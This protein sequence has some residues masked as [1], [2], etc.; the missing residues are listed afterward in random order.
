MWFQS[1]QTAPR[2]SLVKKPRPVVFKQCTEVKNIHNGIETGRMGKEI[3]G[4][5]VIITSHEVTQTFHLILSISLCA[6]CT[7]K[8]VVSGRAVTGGIVKSSLLFS[9]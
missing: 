2:K 8:Y 9:S 3:S 5:S 1:D 7:I 4:P 6:R